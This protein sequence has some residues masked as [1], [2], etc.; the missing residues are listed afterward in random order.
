[1]VDGIK[2]L[3]SEIDGRCRQHLN[4]NYI[5]GYADAL[6][7]LHVGSVAKLQLMLGQ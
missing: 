3:D 4:G 7:Y 1:M 6:G 2:V 5:P